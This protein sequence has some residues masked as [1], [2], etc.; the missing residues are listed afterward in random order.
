MHRGSLPPCSPASSCTSGS[1]RGPRPSCDVRSPCIARPE[2]TSSCSTR[3]SAP[4]RCSWPRRS[5]AIRPW[6]SSVRS[7]TA[8]WSRTDSHTRCWWPAGSALHPSGCWPSVLPSGESRCRWLRVPRRPI[9]SWRV[10]SSSE[11]P[12][13]WKSRPT[14]ARRGSAVWSRCRWR[15]C[16]HESVSTSPTPAVLRPCSARSRGC[17]HRPAYPARSRS[18]ASWRAA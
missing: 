9:G 6:T 7:A 8:G 1:G 16:S 4:G 3:F 15:G 5:P 11:S 13:W 14:T 18:S 17:S 2:T 12:A 10:S